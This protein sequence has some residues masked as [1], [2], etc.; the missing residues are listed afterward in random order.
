MHKINWNSTNFSTTVSARIKFFHPQHKLCTQ[1]SAQNLSIAGAIQNR[2]RFW[3]WFWSTSPTY[4]PGPSGGAIFW[5][6]AKVRTLYLHFFLLQLFLRLPLS[7]T[8]NS[9]WI[10]QSRSS[11]WMGNGGEK[12]PSSTNCWCFTGNSWR[13]RVTKKRDRNLDDAG[14]LCIVNVTG[15]P[16]STLR[17]NSSFKNVREA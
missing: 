13:R 10:F 2:F 9:S 1:P 12:Y 11:W 15:F 4:L 6:L 3:T 14:G 8:S 5:Q 16:W 7:Q 17:P